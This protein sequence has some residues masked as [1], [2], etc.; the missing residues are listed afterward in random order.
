MSADSWVLLPLGGFAGLVAL[1]LSARSSLAEAFLRAVVWWVATVWIMA[2][3][4]GAFSALHGE[5]LR[6]AWMLLGVGLL[7]FGT[8]RFAATRRVMT[9]NWP[10]LRGG[11][12]AFVFA[13]SGL[14]GL[15]L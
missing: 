4:L 12:W 11:E 8:W 6:V 10:Q 15:A 13:G 9:V 5:G 14:M 7:G 3:A 2:N 1:E